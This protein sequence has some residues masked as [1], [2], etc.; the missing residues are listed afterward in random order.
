MVL[1][2]AAGAVLVLAAATATA[3]ESEPVSVTVGAMTVV[4]T[5]FPV[6]GYRVADPSIVK[7]EKLDT[8]KLRVLG[9]KAGDT[10]LQVTGA[11][12]VATLYSVTV[13]ENIKAVLAAMIRDLDTVPEVDLSINLGRVVIKGEVSSIANWQLLQ[14]VIEVY[15]GQCVNL[16]VFRPAPEVMLGL[17]SALEKTGFK[18]LQDKDPSGPAII[19][20]KFSGNNIFVN[21][22][23][24][25]QNDV[26]KIVQVIESQDWLA[27]KKGDKE[28]DSKLAKVNAVLNIGI[29][30]T[31]IELDT[32]FVGVSDE[33]NRQIGVNLAK[34]GLLVVDTTATAFAGT[35]GKDRRSGYTGT[36]IINSGLEGAL[37]FFAG[38]GPGRFRTAGHMTFKNDS[39]EWRIFQSGGTLKVRTATRDTV[40]LEDI[41]YGLIMKARGGLMNARTAALDVEL[42]LSYPIPIGSDYDLKR[43]RIST[44]VTCPLGNTIVMGGMK[45]LIEQSNLQGVPFLRSVPIIQW[46]FAEQSSNLQ[47]TQVLVL[48]SP[49][50]QGAPRP[51]LPV[52]H[53]TVDTESEALKSNRQRQKEKGRRR[54]FFF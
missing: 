18:V 17:K 51:S 50:L 33:Q 25:S 15:R 21:G 11:G 14:K 39:P 27:I 46:F 1:M 49:Q 3:Q 28:V 20:L 10:D 22:S 42:E 29:V 19:G 8:R 36:Y 16:A 37:K 47:D 48:M 43:N 5:P 2:L 35:V 13:I 41:D 12:G 54:F 9:L 30:P 53:E 6:E 23:V 40:D 34:A 38:S 26:N 44:S 45:S 31:M 52:S 7:A 32:V 4:E 24:Y